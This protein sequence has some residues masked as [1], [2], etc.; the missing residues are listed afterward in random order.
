VI[1]SRTLTTDAAGPSLLAATRALLDEAF[2]GGLSDEDWEHARGG[3]HVIA[4]EEQRPLAH[5]AVVPRTLT[6]GGR[7]WASGYVE[8]VATAQQRRGEGL[9]SVVMTALMHELRS[10]FTFGALS[11]GSHHFYERLGWER[12]QGPTFVQDRGTRYRTVEDDD[13]LMVFRFGPSRDI[14]LRAP[15][16][17]DARPGDDW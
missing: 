16:T 17:C 3:W 8:G 2:D 14:D 9:G 11:T 13:G 15:I 5:A 10:R 7:P 6:V 4:F 1:I 12:W